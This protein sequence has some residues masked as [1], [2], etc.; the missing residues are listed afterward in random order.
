MQ[1]RI[2]H[3]TKNGDLPSFQHPKLVEILKDLDLVYDCWNLLRDSKKKYLP[4]E[5][6]EPTDAY[7]NRVLRANYPG[8]YRRAISAFAA[9]LS[10]YQLKGAPQTLMDAQNDIDGRGNSLLKWGIGAD[11]LALRDGG[12]LL[13][14]DMPRGTASSRAQEI[15]EGRLP[16]FTTAERRNVLSWRMVQDGRLMVPKQVAVLEWREVD[17]G[18]FG[19]SLE[20]T[21]RVMNGGEW[22]LL[23]I[24]GMEEMIQI[25][26]KVER[27]TKK[28]GGQASLDFGSASRVEKIDEGVFEMSGGR[29][30]QYPP[31]H[32]YGAGDEPFGEGLPPLLGLAN[33]SLGWFRGNSNLEELLLRCALP[34]AQMRGRLA[35]EIGMLGDPASMIDQSIAVGPNTVLRFDSSDPNAGF[36]FKEPS[37][38]SLSQHIEHLKEIKQLIDSETMSF[39]FGDKQR[40]A[41]EAGLEA[42]QVQATIKKVAQSKRSAYQTLFT[43]W[44]AFTG[45]R[46]DK[47]ADLLMREGLMDR[48]ISNDDLGLAKQLYDSGLIMRDSVTYL[49]ERRGFL[50]DGRDGKKEDQLL[51]EEETRRQ[52]ELNPP[53][54]PNVAN[55]TADNLDANGLPLQ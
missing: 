25:Q 23:R 15:K 40:T 45:E 27:D 52:A 5:Q 9:V 11:E 6:K 8:F 16:T 44:G 54:D 38:S 47:D 30:F 17:D 1:Q 3:D 32:W 4:K 51:A 14:V 53:L 48:E 49:M 10:R 36:E 20:P 42:A 13:M 55:G 26:K 50:P 7:N 21:Y 19:T 18:L 46:V 12:C 24:R 29:L 37:G 31:V 41:T 33:F 34:V 35:Q 28:R 43:L 39:A 2:S 22:Q